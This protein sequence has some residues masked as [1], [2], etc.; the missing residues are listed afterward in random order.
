VFS[1]GRFIDWTGE[2][3]SQG[4]YSHMQPGHARNHL[5]FIAE[6]FEGVHFTSLSNFPC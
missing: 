3:F 1:R 4:V 2:P 6:R 5:R